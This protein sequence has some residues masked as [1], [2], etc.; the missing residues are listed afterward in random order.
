MPGLELVGPIAGCA[1]VPSSDPT[2]AN[3]ESAGLF[4]AGAASSLRG[5]SG[6]ELGWRWLVRAQGPLVKRVPH[7][8][9]GPN[10]GTA[11]YFASEEQARAYYGQ[12]RQHA[13]ASGTGLQAQDTRAHRRRTRCSTSRWGARRP[14]RSSTS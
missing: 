3:M 11:G 2:I 1:Q 4:V 9:Q 13:L 7:W 5:Y 6:A 14:E 8:P 12:L 10:G